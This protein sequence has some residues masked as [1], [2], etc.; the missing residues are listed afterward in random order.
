ML[1]EAPLF[2]PMQIAGFP[3]RWLI[4]NVF[5]FYLGFKGGTLVLIALVSGNFLRLHLHYKSTEPFKSK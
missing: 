4:L 5:V 2:S 3:M 1:S